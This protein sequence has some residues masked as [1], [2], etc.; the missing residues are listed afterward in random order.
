MVNAEI[1]TLHEPDGSPVCNVT[2]DLSVMQLGAASHAVGEIIL[3]RHRG[4]EHETDDVLALREIT[5]IR[6]QL[7]RL[8]DA[9]ANATV[10]MTLG[11]LIAFHDAAHEWVTT[12]T[13]R[14]WLR[15]ADHEALPV[16]GGML[17]PLADLRARAVAATLGPPPVTAP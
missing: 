6:D 8:F 2:F 7:D 10:L 3:E 17:D 9:Q 13:D 11:R 1:Q 15:E 5:A 4:H 14:D 12:R 16:V